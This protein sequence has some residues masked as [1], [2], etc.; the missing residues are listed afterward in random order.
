MARKTMAL[1]AIVAL[2]LAS[3][4][5]MAQGRGGGRGGAP[6]HGGAWHGGDTRHD[7]GGRW[8]GDGWHGSVGL[9]FGGPYWA[10]GWPYAYAYP[11]PYPYR[12]YGYP[13]YAYP[14]HYPYPY[15]EPNIEY[16]PPEPRAYIERSPRAQPTSYWYYCTDPAG[17][18]PY[19]RNCS[20]PWIEVVP[21]NVPGASPAPVGPP[22][23]SGG[24]R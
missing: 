23:T 14:Y 19:V 17:Y 21:E 12:Y 1:A 24:K 11:Y 22:P 5:A 10:W 7:G 13:Y 16:V 3:G 8:H 6:P 20:K 15:Y 18:Y 9:Y 4:V 2:V